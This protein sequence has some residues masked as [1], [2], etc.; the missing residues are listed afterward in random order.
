MNIP[1]PL[2]LPHLVQY[3]DDD[4][5]VIAKAL[6]GSIN[7][8]PNFNYRSVEGV[9]MKFMQGA[10]SP[11]SLAAGLRN[12]APTGREDLFAELANPLHQAFYALRPKAIV[13]VSRKVL[14]IPG[15][16][17]GLTVPFDPGFV[18]V[19][20]NEE[21]IVLPYRLYWKRRSLA[22]RSLR[23]FF[24]LAH[25]LLIEDDDVADAEIELFTMSANS[26]DLRTLVNHRSRDFR[27]ISVLEL[28]KFLKTYAEAYEMACAE[29]KLMPERLKRQ[30]YPRNTSLDLFPR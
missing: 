24:S 26:S 8:T 29:A 25:E 16:E 3:C 30:Q 22:E 20:E 17:G 4:P 1:K 27:P 14:K 11:D 7:R 5:R 13:P 15:V 2:A 10:F 19:P 28:N 23:L 9:L 6:I 18:Y 12:A 21:R